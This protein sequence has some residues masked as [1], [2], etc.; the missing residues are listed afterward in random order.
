MTKRIFFMFRLVLAWYL[1]FL[2][3]FIV[4]DSLWSPLARLVTLVG[5]VTLVFVVIRAFSHLARV[6]L[7]AG[8]PKPG[9]LANRQTRQIEVP[10]EADEAFDLLDATIRELPGIDQIDS[11]RGHLQIRASAR[12]NDPYDLKLLGRYNPFG[13][14][15]SQH[16]R[17]LATV[18]RGDGVSSFTV[19]C[20]P[21]LAPWSDWLQVDD[22]VNLEN[23]E[24]IVR[25]ISLR[26]SQRRRSEQSAA[27]Q[28]VTEKELATAKLSLLQAQVEPHFLYNT[29]ASAQYL[30]RTDA[31]SA[32]AMLGH[33]IQ[34]LRHSLPRT[35]RALS[36]LGEELERSRAYLEILKI[37]MGPRLSLQIDVPDDLLP[38]PLPP[39][40]LQTL[41]ENA[42][43]HGLEPRPGEGCIW[44]FGRRNDARIAVTV[45]DD[46]LGFGGETNGTGIGLKNVRE[47]LRLVYGDAATLT[48][49]ANFPSGVATTIS[50]PASFT[51]G[52]AA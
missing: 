26:V 39:M 10:F 15:V 13:W 6:R 45:A 8:K 9:T 41:V 50:V 34:Y 49:A 22:G 47:R 7:I 31:A 18:T 23:A 36:T 11:M 24:A 35:D 16:N 3:L 32:D 4:A 44:I 51:K 17:I 1:L 21:V 43:K 29:L 12:Y 33:L 19:V 40:M 27:T 20:E 37:R 5:F 14:I 38:T 42:I 30:T 48:I 52:D 28:T 25:A 2:V 46:G